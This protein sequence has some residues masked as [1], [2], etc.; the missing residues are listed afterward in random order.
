ARKPID[1][2]PVRLEHVANRSAALGAAPGDVQSLPA[3][4]GARELQPRSGH[5]RDEEERSHERLGCREKRSDEAGAPVGRPLLCVI[6]A[7]ARETVRTICRCTVTIP[8]VGSSGRYPPGTGDLGSGVAAGQ[9]AAAGG[10]SWCVCASARSLLQ[11][12]SSY[13]P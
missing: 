11:S 13:L 7:V 4:A 9:R 12:R 10:P 3:A 6:G 1:C 2:L 5:V 8:V